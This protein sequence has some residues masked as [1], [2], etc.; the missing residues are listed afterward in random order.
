MTLLPAMLLIAVVADA[1]D[2][3]RDRRDAARNATPGS[4]A[5]AA[6]SIDRDID[7]AYSLFRLHRRSDALSAI[8]AAKKALAR[9]ADVYTADERARLDAQ[10]TA[11]R[12]CLSTAAAPPMARLTVR[13]RHVE[14]EAGQP[15]ERSAGAGVYIRVDDIPVGRTSQR[16][17]L[18]AQVP[19]GEIRVTAIIPPHTFGERFVS[20]PPGG[21]ET[22]TVML[23]PDKEV[24][25]ETDLVLVEAR[26]GVL[27]A[28]A[29][30]LSLRF[31]ENNRPIALKRISAI[32]LLDAAGNV[33]RDLSPLFRVSGTAIVAADPG[34]V[35]T[36]LGGA[37]SGS[38]RLRVAA[39][40]RAGFVRLNQIGLKVADRRDTR[41]ASRHAPPV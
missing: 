29:R 35:I 36:A 9:T 19:S 32:E 23:D 24:T 22:V 27:R 26:E 10:L 25:D 20:L 16:G 5:P 31:V 28:D 2:M 1:S 38:I 17:E 34:A 13:A 14:T 33:V 7:R 40:D 30:S 8:D 39:A 15:A 41:R 6:R 3:C 18:T 37:S 21:E 11:L 12:S 4:T